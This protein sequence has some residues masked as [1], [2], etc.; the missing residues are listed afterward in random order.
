M[1]AVA[2]IS[3]AFPI[4]NLTSTYKFH[5]NLHIWWY[6]EAEQLKSHHHLVLIHHG[7]Y[8]GKRDQITLQRDAHHA[9]G[10]HRMLNYQRAIAW[11]IKIYS[12]LKAQYRR[13][14]VATNIMQKRR[15][16][17]SVTIVHCRCSK[18]H[19]FPCTTLEL[20]Q[21][22]EK[23]NVPVLSCSLSTLC[24]WTVATLTFAL[25]SLAPVPSSSLPSSGL[26][27]SCTLSALLSA[28]S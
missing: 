24:C 9:T 28:L 26:S 21:A 16:L 19:R 17:Q 6:C 14:A 10:H 18:H 12:H 27:S 22:Y 2:R 4:L 23:E 3:S 7:P 5:H 1:S 25:P 8:F 15:H 11:L 20:I 13:A